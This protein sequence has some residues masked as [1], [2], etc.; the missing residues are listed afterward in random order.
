M[1]RPKLYA[2]YRGIPIYMRQSSESLQPWLRW[3][4]TGVYYGVLLNHDDEAIE[5]ARSMIDAI[6]EL[7]SLAWVGDRLSLST[8]F[9][10]DDPALSLGI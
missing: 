8:A 2:T 1:V 7:E 9:Q 3:E 4:R 10:D 5:K 6:L